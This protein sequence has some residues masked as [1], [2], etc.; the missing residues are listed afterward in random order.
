VKRVVFG[1]VDL[2]VPEKSG[3]TG[4]KWTGVEKDSDWVISDYSSPDQ[5]K[6][7]I[8]F[9]PG[10][11]STVPTCV[12]SQGWRNAEGVRNKCCEESGGEGGC[13]I[14]P[15]NMLDLKG[16][17]I[18]AWVVD[19]TE[20]GPESLEVTSLQTGSRVSVYKTATVTGSAISM[21]NYMAPNAFSFVCFE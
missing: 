3:T 12:V 18:P 13:P 21:Y 10:L 19:I 17:L 4:Y 7:Q 1:T 15:C 16:A 5:G 20:V 11:F 14:S 2:T 8:D 6:I 9:K